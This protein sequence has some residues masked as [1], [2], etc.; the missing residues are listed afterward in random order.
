MYTQSARR[1]P[2]SCPQKSIE[3][4]DGVARV[5]HA[6]HSSK[7]T[8]KENQLKNVSVRT[9]YVLKYSDH[10]RG[11]F[12]RLTDFGIAALGCIGLHRLHSVRHVRCWVALGA[13][14][15]MLVLL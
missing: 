9:S 5:W 1:V 4:A 10:P 3:R 13:T 11:W 6:H 7:C 15:P 2:S 8:R 12:L 14:P